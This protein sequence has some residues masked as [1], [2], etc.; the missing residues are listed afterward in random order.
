MVKQKI[1]VEKAREAAERK[2]TFKYRIASLCAKN[3]PREADKVKSKGKEMTGYKGFLFQQVG[4]E[5]RTGRTRQDGAGQEVVYESVWM[6]MVKEMLYRGNLSEEEGN[7]GYYQFLKITEPVF[8]DT[9]EYMCYDDLSVD[10]AVVVA[11]FAAKVEDDVMIDEKVVD[12]L[13]AE[14]ANHPIDEREG[15]YFCSHNGDSTAEY[16]RRIEMFIIPGEKQDRDNTDC[17]LS[18][19]SGH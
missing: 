13:H 19:V 6:D 1:K 9:S 11:R 12:G 2:K 4:L 16:L 17:D 14:W 10:L 5:W 3:E 15:E 18:F 8:I 7:V